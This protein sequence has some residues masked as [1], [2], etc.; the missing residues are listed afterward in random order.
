M[1]K[2]NRV[3]FLCNAV[4]K[5]PFNYVYFKI[6]SVDRYAIIPRFV[7]TRTFEFLIN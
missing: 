7:V 3:Y 2:T 5:Q 1:Y 4:P 6:R